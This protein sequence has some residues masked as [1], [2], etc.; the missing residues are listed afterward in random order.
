[1]LR[2]ENN[3]KL[4]KRLGDEIIRFQDILQV[5]KKVIDTW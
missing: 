1:M 2:E 3:E 5:E 4:I